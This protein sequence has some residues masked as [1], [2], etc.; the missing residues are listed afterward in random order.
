MPAKSPTRVG[1]I[2]QLKVTLEDIEPPIWRRL[3]VPGEITL[4]KL[5]SVIQLAMGWLDYHLHEFRIG[6][7]TYGEPDPEFDDGREVN[8]DRPA[9]LSR[10]V[11][12][13]GEEF[14]Y[15]YDFGDGWTHHI[16]VEDIRAP[17]PRIRC[18]RVLAGARA[19]PPE[20]VGGPSGYADFLEAIGDPKHDEHDHMLGWVGGAFDPEAFDVRAKNREFDVVS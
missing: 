8:N 12:S 9:R 14:V 10:A 18:P 2:Y 19:C 16:V 11:P 17:E 20:D 4:A 13:V 1:D 15:E 5:H 7:A 3:E 6:D